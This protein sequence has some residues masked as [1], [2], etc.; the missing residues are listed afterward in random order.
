MGAGLVGG[1]SPSHPP[2]FPPLKKMGRGVTAERQPAATGMA[3]VGGGVG[4]GGGRG[5][6]GNGG[7]AR[8]GPYRHMHPQTE[9]R[10][11]GGEGVHSRAG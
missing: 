10:G 1:F 6:E 3:A 8:K 7:S 9:G 4:W 5:G 11:R 2:S